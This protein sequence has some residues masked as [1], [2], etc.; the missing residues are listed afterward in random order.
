[1]SPLTPLIRPDTYF[2]EHDL[3][4]LRILAVLAV[5]SLA[6]PATLYGVGWIFTTHIDGTVVITNPERPPDSVCDSTSDVID[7]AGCDQPKQVE[8]NVDTVIW[9]PISGMIGLALLAGPIVLLIAGILLH[10]G[11]WLAGG[12][13]GLPPSFGIAA[14]GL[15]PQLLGIIVILPILYVVIDPITV[16]PAGQISGTAVIRDQLQG[17]QPVSR[18]VTVIAAFWS[19]VIWRFGL[20][21]KRALGR[22]EAW[23]VGGLVAGSLAVLSLL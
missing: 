6:G 11:S 5:L 12:D 8:R 2:A 10:I 22:S 19:A 16:T 15:V 18:V 17:V 1:M 13:G 20:D 21:H 14:W 9:S 4:G 7:Q 3:N 23:V